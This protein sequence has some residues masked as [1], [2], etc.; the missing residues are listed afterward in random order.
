MDSL[1]V[2][3]VTVALNAGDVL[4]RCLDSVARQEGVSVE[5]IVIDGGSND[6]SVD[7]LKG[8][9][10][11]NLH[12]ISEKDSGIA[13]AMNKG[14]GMSRGRW[15]YFLQADDTLLETGTL[16]RLV[17]Q[18]DESGAEL[19]AA[20]IRLGDRP[21]LNIPCGE[22]KVGWPLTSPF[23]QAFRHQ[24]LLISRKAWNAV[25][26][27]DLKYQITM[28]FDWMLRAYWKGIKALRVGMELA[29]VSDEGL[30][31]A[32]SG[33][34]FRQRLAEEQ[35]ARLA[36]AKN[37]FWRVLYMLFWLAYRPYRVFRTRMGS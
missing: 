19:V 8:C 26:E 1:D 25:G 29:L 3:I 32:V 30:S 17:S 18:G 15:L 31:S 35:K 13:D 24:G 5:H 36:N 16:A 33:G 9:N 6:G 23:K 2:S 20:G 11:S 28:D 27:Y 21:F 22:V 12:W 10:A 34:L 14:A 4:G 7:L 37:G